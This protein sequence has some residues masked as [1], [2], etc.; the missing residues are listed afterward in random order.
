M[1]GKYH[2]SGIFKSSAGAVYDGQWEN[3]A[4]HGN[5][6]FTWPNGSTYEGEWLFGKENGYG[7]FKTSSHSHSS[8][9]ATREHDKSIRQQVTL[10]NNTE[11]SQKDDEYQITYEGNWK[12]G[13][14]EGIGK[15]YDNDGKIIEGKFVAGKVI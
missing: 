2:G 7:I 15:L 5:G 14:Y 13:M 10:N 3:G 1:N 8:L 12:N 11:L 9:K 4:F 6:K